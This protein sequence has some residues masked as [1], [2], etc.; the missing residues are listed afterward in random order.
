[1]DKDKSTRFMLKLVGDVSTSLAAGLLVVGERSGLFK[2]MAGAGP[3][4]HDALAARTGI[5]ARY[6]EEWLAAMAG[7]GY[8]EYDPAADTFALPDEHALFLTD[9]S[10][11]YYLGGLFQGLPGLLAM[12]PKLIAAFKT[13]KGISFA[14]FGAELPAALEAMNRSVYENRLVRTWLPAIPEVVARLQAGGRALDVGCG[15]GVIPLT[16]AKAFPSATVA[17]LDFDARS[18]DI[19]RGH[20]REA[21]LGE[22]V[23]F[24]AEPVEALPGEPG[25]DLITSF[26]VIHDLPDPLGAMKRIHAALREGGTYLMVEPKVDERLEKS[27]QNPFARMFRAMSCLHCVPQSLAQGGPGLGAC[28]GEARARAMARAAGFGHFE[29]LEVRSPA[30]AFYA[31]R[32]NGSPEARG[33]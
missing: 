13:G 19:A 21:G 26:D 18:I 7:A 9:A 1:M 8:V 5:P 23:T 22:R 30:M 20:A 6:V 14:E 11:E 31:L 10:S 15:T 16:L 33:A 28:W 27:V 17:G 3:L 25:W 32:S 24:I 2:A 4:S 29:R 12:T